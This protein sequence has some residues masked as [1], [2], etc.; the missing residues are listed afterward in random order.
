MSALPETAAKTAIGSL[1]SKYADAP[2]LSDE[3]WAGVVGAKCVANRAAI[4]R[5]FD[6]LDADPNR[7]EERDKV[8]RRQHVNEQDSVEWWEEHAHHLRRE[9]ED[10]LAIHE[11]VKAGTMADYSPDERGADEDSARISR[12]R[13]DFANAQALPKWRAS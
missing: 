5:I 1:L 11:R 9:Y 10:A 12:E 7:L 2:Y 8:L 13:A 4:R 3:F 6:Q